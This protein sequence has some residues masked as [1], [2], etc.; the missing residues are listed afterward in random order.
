MYLFTMHSGQETVTPVEEMLQTLSLHIAVSRRRTLADWSYDLC[1][2]FWRLYANNRS[3]A[4]LIV[5]DRRIDLRP[6][7]IY[8]IPAGVVFRTGL[9][10]EVRHD[11]VHFYLNGFPASLHRRLFP[12]PHAVP[13][14]AIL[15]PLLSRWRAGLKAGPA[16]D[17]TAFG[18]ASA[19]AHAAVATAFGTLPSEEREACRRWLTQANDVRPAL[20]ALEEGLAH[21]PDNETL[22]AL[23]SL[24]AN[25]FIR[26]FRRA[27]GVTPAKYGLERRLAVA[28]GWLVGSPR[29]IEAIAAATG[30]TDRFHFS[31]SFKARYGVAPAAYRHLHHLRS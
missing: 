15:R 11:Y 29:P 6:D 12:A 30:F 23:C 25:H 22:A 19:L 8:L 14:D 20:R 18:W 1:S 26:V 9:E 7:R 4:F 27:V 5:Q 10:R 17:W 24:S 3:G 28:A 2:P 13:I 21:P 16:R 31:R